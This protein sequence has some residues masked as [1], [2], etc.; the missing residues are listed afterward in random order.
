LSRLGRPVWFHSCFTEDHYGQMLR[1]HLDA[2]GV[3]LAPAGYAFDEVEMTYRLGPQ[4]RFAGNLQVV[5]GAF[6]SGTRTEVAYS[7]RIEV[8]PRLSLEPRISVTD[9]SLPEGNFVTKLMTS[10]AT[11]TMTPRTFVGALVQYNSSTNAVTANVRYRWEYRPGSDLFIV[12]TEGRT[13]AANQL[14]T[15]QQRGFVVKYTRLLRF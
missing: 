3:R 15:L 1:T 2:A 10:R 8:T 5:R 11:F 7:G 9:A 4:R 6:Y 12:Y 14:D 13:T